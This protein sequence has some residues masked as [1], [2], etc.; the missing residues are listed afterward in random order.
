MVQ[1]KDHSKLT[2]QVVTRT[3]PGA[4]TGV[5]LLRS[6]HYMFQADNEITHSRMIR[7][8]YQLEPFTRLNFHYSWLNLKIKISI[9]EL[10]I[11]SVSGVTWSDREGSKADRSQYFKAA[12]PGSDTK[13]TLNLAGLLVFTDA[14][15]S[16]YPDTGTIQ[17]SFLFNICFIS[18]MLRIIYFPVN[19]NK[20]NGYESCMAV[21]CFHKDQ[22]CDGKTDCVDG[23]DEDDCKSLI[24]SQVY[25]D[26]DKFKQSLFFGGEWIGPLK[27]DDRMDFRMLRRNRFHVIFVLLL[28]QLSPIISI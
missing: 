20:D 21:G 19:C 16:Q 24:S 3:I 10:Y 11:R 2:V 5:S 4:F 6:A 25:K 7:A 14:R 9:Y 8:L 13:R 1:T 27:K 28:S 17:L 15:I 22:R 18:R 26:W 23:S 12:N